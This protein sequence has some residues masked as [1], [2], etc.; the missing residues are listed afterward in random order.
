MKEHGTVREPILGGDVPNVVQTGRGDLSGWV[1]LMEAVE[2]L[3]PVW[4]RR[5]KVQGRGDWRL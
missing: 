3:C 4:P 1:E 2:L 5:H